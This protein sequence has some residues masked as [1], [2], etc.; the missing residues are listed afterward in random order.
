MSD[1]N[2][3]VTRV[4]YSPR[5]S[6]SNE[7]EVGSRNKLCLVH[8]NKMIEVGDDVSLHFR[9]GGSHTISL[10]YNLRVGDRGSNGPRIS[11]S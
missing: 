2:G 11:A 8:I 1:N 5:A 6:G 10:T 4:W 9:G 7:I 3:V